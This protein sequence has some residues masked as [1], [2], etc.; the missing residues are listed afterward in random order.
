VSDSHGVGGVVNVTGRA[1]RTGGRKFGRLTRT[2]CGK[3]VRAKLENAERFGFVTNIVER[4]VI[5]AN[6]NDANVNEK[7]KPRDAAQ[8]D[9]RVRSFTT[10]AGKMFSSETIIRI[11]RPKTFDQDRLELPYSN[12]D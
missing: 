4:N 5:R 11:S 9:L 10:I 8:R 12:V 1:P 3:T 7:K 6:G 2:L